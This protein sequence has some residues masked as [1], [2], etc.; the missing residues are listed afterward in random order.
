MGNEII[1]EM[2]NITKMFPGVLALD[3]VRLSVLQGEVHALL[4]ENGA[5][6]STLMKIL[7]GAYKKDHGEIKLFGQTQELG[8]PKTSE[9]LG[10]G[11]IY[12]ESNLIPALSVAEN[13]FLGHPIMKNKARIDWKQMNYKAS[14]LLADLE[15]EIDPHE[16]VRDLG[17]AEQQ[18]VE[19]AKVLSKKAKIVIMDEPTSPLSTTETENLFKIIRKLK[20]SGVSIIYISHRLEEVKQIC[21]RATIMR[22]GVTIVDV[23]V[24]DVTIDGIIKYMVGRELKDKFPR[25]EKTIG[26]EVFR[27]E[28]MNAGPKVKNVSFS[29]RAGEILC[30]GGLVGAGRTET[31]RAIFGLS[32][33][34]TGKIF[35][36]KQQVT[37]NN[38]QDA[39]RAGIGFVTEDR[40]GEGLVLKMSV[41]SN[42]TLAALKDF[43]KSYHI[44]LKQENHIIDDYINKMH[45][46]TPTSNQLVENLSGGNQQKVVLA[47]WLLSKCK[48]LIFDEPTKGID[49]GAKIEV[50]NIINELSR[51]GTAILVITSEIQE[52]LGICDRSI[53]MARGQI[54]GELSRTEANQE[55]VMLLATGVNMNK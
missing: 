54:S 27:V 7:S 34:A 49:V 15:M 18:M 19:V 2:T 36:N 33:S 23:N 31:A 26:E 30:I 11:I 38:P 45:I 14:E 37:I 48:I 35:V 32:Q 12:Q 1:L 47:K 16:L 13:I 39:I 46:K 29:I 17:I 20:A 53:I 51:E 22:D 43:T 24:S 21:D 55:N 50:Y 25:V 44:G 4:G 3:K 41:G 10:I 9:D 28:N 6:K 8:S 40:K 52:L 42:I 5:G